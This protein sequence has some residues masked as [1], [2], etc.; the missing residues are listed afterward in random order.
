MLPV[1]WLTGNTSPLHVCS[2]TV[3]SFPWRN[4]AGV[5]AQA[6]ALRREEPVLGWAGF[7][8][9]ALG[10]A[11]F[12][13]AGLRVPGD[14][15]AVLPVSDRAPS[16]A[17][18]ARLALAA[19]TLARSVSARSRGPVPLSGT[20]AGPPGRTTSF[21]SILACTRAAAGAFAIA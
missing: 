6:D 12:L 13:A 8:S 18:L 11:D 17:P 3:P 14:L 20:P 16:L 7:G 10:S 19:S 15:A 21:P 9:A 5:A 4:G 1:A 2:C